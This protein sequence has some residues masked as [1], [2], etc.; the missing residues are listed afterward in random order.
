MKDM[1]RLR[2]YLLACCAASA[3]T[4][5]RGMAQG[6]V[7]GRVSIQERA[8][9]TA[10]DYGSTVIYLQ[11][12]G[13]RTLRAPVVKVP[14][15]MTARQFTP[16]VRVVS[17]GSTVEY[18]NQDPFSHN[19]FSTAAGASFDL[20]TYPGGITRSVTFRKTGAFPIY[21]NI[22]SGMTAYVVVVATPYHVQAGADGRWSFSGVAAGSYELHVW[23]ERAP[24]VVQALDVPVAGLI[25]ITS[26]LDAR[27]YEAKPH[28]NK[29]GREY[30]SSGKDRY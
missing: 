20:G 4:P 30:T 26:A 8:G 7:S 22:H 23:H 6:T 16:H 13:G 17:Q 24:E 25:G 5:G 19:I 1:I 2:Q 15:A 10:S 14:I 3:I 28:L 12:T 21:C 18:P 11:P 29:F 9:Q 27:G